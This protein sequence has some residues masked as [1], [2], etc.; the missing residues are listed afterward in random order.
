[1]RSLL[2]STLVWVIVLAVLCVLPV[3]QAQTPSPSPQVTTLPATPTPPPTPLLKEDIQSVSLQPGDRLIGTSTVQVVDPTH[4]NQVVGTLKADEIVE[5]I[6]RTGDRQ[7]WIVKR[8]D[9]SMGAV[10]APPG[11]SSTQAQV[12]RVAPTVATLRQLAA[13]KHI[14]VGVDFSARWLDNGTWQDVVATQFDLGVVDWGMYWPG[15]EPSE[16]HFNFGTADKQVAFALAS[17]LQIR[18]HPLVW[19]TTSAGSPQWINQGNF[20]RDQ[21]IGL[22]R[23]HVTALVSHFKG[24]IHEWVVVN[25]PYNL[26]PRPNDVFYNG[27]GMAYI[28]IAFQA[29]RDAD[30]SAVLIFN[31]FGNHTASGVNTRV[32]HE[33]VQRLK[34]K[35]L[36][37]GV[38]LQMHLDGA[39]PPAKEDVVATMKSYGVPVYVTELDVTL[40][41]VPGTQE[42]RFAAQAKVYAQM[43]E[44]CLESGV[45]RSFTTWGI[46]D[47]YSWLEYGLS[48]N[49]NPTLFDDDLN[50]KPAYFALVDV[51]LRP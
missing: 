51:L 33:I 50:P 17:G 49:A 38:G 27:I 26:P 32:T 4:H 31:D 19:A 23:S 13:K 1:M 3:T 42:A 24:K 37:D 45:C 2:P 16:G 15:V 11:V 8:I 46:G 44:A 5:A 35:G 21:L 34:A 10:W 41:D 9:G 7:Y 18:G 30:P 40:K 20:G 39:K 47:K 28:D 25:E 43:L 22:L 14:T 29:A 6:R 48:A 12:W 36:I